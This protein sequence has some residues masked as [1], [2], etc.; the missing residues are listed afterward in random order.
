[1]NGTKRNKRKYQLKIRIG[2]ETTIDIYTYRRIFE[3]I[4]KEIEKKKMKDCT[5]S[6]YRNE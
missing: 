1:M 2:E 3:I 5:R 4:T 6:N